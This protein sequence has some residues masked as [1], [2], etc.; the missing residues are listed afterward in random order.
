M[1]KLIITTAALLMSALSFAASTPAD[2]LQDTLSKIRTMQANFTQIITDED[3]KGAR[4][5]KGSVA[6]KR[7]RQFRWTI[8]SPTQQ[9][10]IAT[11][12]KIWTY[13]PRLKQA[14]VT[15]QPQSFG[16]TPASFLSGSTSSII[17]SYIVAMKAGPGSAEY[18]L[19]ARRKSNKFQKIVLRFNGL[20]LREMSFTDELGHTSQLSFSNI[21]LNQ[22]LNPRLFAFKPAPDVDVIR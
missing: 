21:K 2:Q 14:S 6:L 7:P 13:Q 19:E 4:E 1:K 10:I 20:N 8:A 9:D 12:D 22:D 15:Q 16:N 17:K 3:Q 18:Y 5:L 11:G